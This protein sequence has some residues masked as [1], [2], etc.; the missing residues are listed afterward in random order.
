ML[1]HVQNSPENSP[2]WMDELS[3]EAKF[4]YEEDEG[5]SVLRRYYVAYVVAILTLSNVLSYTDRQVFAILLP[6]IKEE[7]QASDAVMGLLGGPAFM[8]AYVL[9]SLPLAALAD[10]TS[11]RAVL[12]FSVMTWSAATAWCGIA[13][14]ILQLTF[15]RIGVGIGEAG[16]SPPAQSLISST[17]SAHNRSLALGVFTTGTYLGVVAGMWGGAALDSAIGWHNTFLVLAVPGM[18]VALLIYTTLPR[19]TGQLAVAATHSMLAVIRYCWAIKSLRCI[20]LGAGI[21]NI[22]T[23]GL[24]VWMPSYLL[25]SH[26]LSLL[27]A[28]FWNGITA[29]FG[30]IIGSLAGGHLADRMS[31][32]NQKSQLQIPAL[33]MALAA[34]FFAMQLL[35]PVEWVWYFKGETIPLVALLTLPASFFMGLWMPAAFGAIQNIV[36]IEFRA[37][38]AACLIVVLFLFGGTIGPIFTGFI[39]DYLTPIVGEEALRYAMLSSIVTLLVGAAI[40]LWGA[41]YYPNDLANPR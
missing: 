13:S 7:F 11:R 2:G 29:A 1:M 40:F 17:V 15:G 39:S 32:K 5:G 3:E 28:G 22:F 20:M 37:Q 24:G 12:A 6:S 38:A 41:R 33:G 9:F 35:W 14:S 18:I 16:G 4:N 10:R 27:E 26:G 19:R 8:I 21:M 36:R 23:F 34:P 30:G 25:R 31:A